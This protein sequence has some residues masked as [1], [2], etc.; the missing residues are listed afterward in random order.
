MAPEQLPDVELLPAVPI[1]TL[2]VLAFAESPIG[3][4]ITNIAPI[5]IIS[6]ITRP[7][8]N[9]SLRYDLDRYRNIGTC[10]E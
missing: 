4:G 7:N 2:Q 10:T 1:E 3:L 6:P 9:T 5:P 8:F